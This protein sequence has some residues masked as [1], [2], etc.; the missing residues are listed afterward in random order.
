[1]SKRKVTFSSNSYYYLS[2]KSVDKKI[3]FKGVPDYLYFLYL[4]Y[5]LN[6]SHSLELRCLNLNFACQNNKYFKPAHSIAPPYLQVIGFCLLPNSFS[7][8]VKQLGAN[9]ISDFMQ[10][11][12]TSYSLHYNRRYRRSGPIFRGPFQSVYIEKTALGCALLFLHLQSAKLFIGISP[13]KLFS[14]VKNYSW[15]SL[16]YYLGE[17][18]WSP[19]LNKN[20]KTAPSFYAQPMKELIFKKKSNRPIC[21]KKVLDYNIQQFILN[22]NNFLNI[23]LVEI[24]INGFYFLSQIEDFTLS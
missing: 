10:R 21:F 24:L 19:L 11:L 17:K 18:T 12:G 6:R 23:L 9:D 20:K 15:S 7:L 2:N 13:Q 8:I 16:P 14:Q 4:L 5:Y 22:V 3:L 1:M